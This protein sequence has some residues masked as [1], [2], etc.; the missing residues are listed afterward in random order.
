MILSLSREASTPPDETIFDPHHP[1]DDAADADLDARLAEKY[2]RVLR[3][4]RGIDLD[5]DSETV[6]WRR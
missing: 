1:R 3:V 4:V 6:R 5:D 2:L